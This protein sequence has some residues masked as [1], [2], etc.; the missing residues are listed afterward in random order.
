MKIECY[1]PFGIQVWLQNKPA[2][3]NKCISICYY[4]NRWLLPIKYWIWWKTNGAVKGK[5]SCFDF[6]MEIFGL[7]IGYTDYNY[8]PGVKRTSWC[9]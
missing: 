6:N 2:H 5:D 9:N 3:L 4:L 1:K 7:H 8:S